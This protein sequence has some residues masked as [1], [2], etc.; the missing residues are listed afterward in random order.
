MI[1]M[2]SSHMFAQKLLSYQNKVHTQSVTQP[3]VTSRILDLQQHKCRCVRTE[4]GRGPLNSWTLFFPW[5]TLFFFF[6]VF[7]FK[8][9]FVYLL[10]AALG[11]RC[12]TRAFSGC[13]KRELLFVALR[14]LLVAV[15]SLVAEHEL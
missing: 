8:K 2:W 11:L 9:L 6:F 3:A 4:D 12:C 10:L 1:S 13:G 15:A 14:G 5:K 7:N